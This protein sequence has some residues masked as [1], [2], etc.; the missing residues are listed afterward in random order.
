[1]ILAMRPGIGIFLDLIN[2]NHRKALRMVLEAGM[3]TWTQEARVAGALY[4]T[5]CQGNSPWQKNGTTPLVR[6]LK[7]LRIQVKLPVIACCISIERS[8]K[9][10][11]KQLVQVLENLSTRFAS[12]LARWKAS[13]SSILSES[14]PIHLADDIVDR[15]TAFDAAAESN[16]I[17]AAHLE[18]EIDIEVQRSEL[19]F[20]D[21]TSELSIERYMA[22]LKKCFYL[23][24][25]IH[26]GTALQ[27]H[28]VRHSPF[29]E[30]KNVTPEGN[31]EVAHFEVELYSRPWIVARN[32]KHWYARET[33]ADA[34]VKENLA[35]I[36]NFRTKRIKSIYEKM[37][38]LIK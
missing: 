15:V 30:W 16:E 14:L 37:T 24:R 6:L 27:S 11:N 25:V 33:D 29:D 4:L 36:A 18:H 3:S 2:G 31:S 5:H 17:L 1:V 22:W 9:Y 21:S 7:S 34:F 35:F 28:C 12:Q 8:K 23:Q 19:H 20:I 26:M 10:V 32:M 13:I 38:D